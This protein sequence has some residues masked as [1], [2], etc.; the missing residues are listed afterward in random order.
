M[1]GG[2]GGGAG[3]TAPEAGGSRDQ[4]CPSSEV[5][6]THL[7]KGGRRSRAGGGRRWREG[8]LGLGHEGEGGGH[9]GG[10]GEEERVVTWV[11]LPLFLHHQLGSGP[12]WPRT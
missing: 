1:G 12:P 8:H 7:E 5:I 9:G 2:D 3:G 4:S 11:V 6:A 10:W